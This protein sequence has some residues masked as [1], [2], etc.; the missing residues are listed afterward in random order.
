LIVTGPYGAKLEAISDAIDILPGESHAPSTINTAADPRTKSYELQPRVGEHSE[1]IFLR[2]GDTLNFPGRAGAATYTCQ[3]TDSEVQVNSSV[4][5]AVQVAES[6]EADGVADTP[7]EE[8]EDE[9]LDDDTITAT[10]L[11]QK[12]SQPRA[13]PQLPNQR[14]VVVVQETPTAIRVK[15][16]LSSPAPTDHEKPEPETEAFST[17]R[18]GESQDRPSARRSNLLPNAGA[19]PTIDASVVDSTIEKRLSRHSRTKISPQVLIPP[20]SSRKRATP[21][22]EDEWE[23]ESEAVSRGNKRAK[24]SD[25]DTQDSRMSNVDVDLAPPWKTPAKAKTRQ[26]EVAKTEVV[27]EAEDATPARSQRSSQRSTTS[28]SAEPYEGPTPRVAFSNSGIATTGHV[29][30]FLKKRG[31]FVE[32]L[33]DDFDV[34]W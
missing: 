24:R 19:S 29:V 33:T 34:L 3:W 7:E 2:H 23:A 10:P 14:S 22:I 20:K 21:V 13:T 26:S 4:T 27:A 28:V 31:T 11:N 25:D 12:K 17:V 6:A 9:D 30:K 15:T 18:T 1:A 8:T 16:P 32:N 5:D